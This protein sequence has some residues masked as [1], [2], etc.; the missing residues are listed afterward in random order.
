MKSVC[1]DYQGGLWI[2]YNDERI[3]HWAGGTLKSYTNL[4][5]SPG[6]SFLQVRSVLEDREQRVWAGVLEAPEGGRCLFRLENIGFRP[7]LNNP[8]LGQ[9]V[10]SALNTE[11]LALYQDRQGVLWAGTQAGLARWDGRDWKLFTT[12]DGLTPTESGRSLTT[13]RGISGLGPSRAA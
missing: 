6:K 12:R 9:P 10:P 3:D 4:W 2:G 5:P 13:L 11:V 8:G 7:V 1:N